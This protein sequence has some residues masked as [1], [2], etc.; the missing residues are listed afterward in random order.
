MNP[1]TRNYGFGC[2]LFFF[3]DIE[4]NGN[5]LFRITSFLPILMAFVLFFTRV[6]SLGR[7]RDK[8]SVFVFV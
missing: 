1:V 7:G 2:F 6:W 3:L 8:S 4:T 5:F